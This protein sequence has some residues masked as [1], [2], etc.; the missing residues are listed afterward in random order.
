MIAIV[1]LPFETRA[2]SIAARSPA[3]PEPTMIMS[4][5]SVSATA[6][7]RVECKLP[8]ATLHEYKGELVNHVRSNARPRLLEVP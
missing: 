1:A 6:T 7:T 4:Y 8:F 5:L 2:A 3:I